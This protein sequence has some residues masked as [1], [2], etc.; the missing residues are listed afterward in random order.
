MYAIQAA[1]PEVAKSGIKD[2]VR[3]ETEFIHVWCILY[4]VFCVH[5]CMYADISSAWEHDFTMLC[6][7]YFGSVYEQET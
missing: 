6:L 3:N 4:S 1:G 2:K 7:L 5:V